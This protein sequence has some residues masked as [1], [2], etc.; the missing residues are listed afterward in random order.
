MED[1]FNL[2][3]ESS[4]SS[5]ISNVIVALQMDNKVEAAQLAEGQPQLTM[6]SITSLDDLAPFFASICENVTRQI[7]RNEGGTAGGGGGGSSSLSPDMTERIDRIIEA[8]FLEV[9]PRPT[10]SKTAEAV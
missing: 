8:D 1:R 7:A 2:F 4:E 6:T 9:L 3:V 5:S 10:T